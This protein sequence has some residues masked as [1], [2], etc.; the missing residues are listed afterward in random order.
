MKCKFWKKCKLYDESSP[1]CNINGG[2]YFEDRPA[3]CFRRMEEEYERN[4]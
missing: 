1:T 2:I 4:N 3:G